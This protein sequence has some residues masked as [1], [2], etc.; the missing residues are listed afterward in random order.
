M[1]I[2]REAVRKA[3]SMVGSFV[4]MYVLCAGWTHKSTA[5]S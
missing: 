4:A 3:T 1:P 2:N 5:K